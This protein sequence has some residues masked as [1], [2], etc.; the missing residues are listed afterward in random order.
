MI[1]NFDR[2]INGNLMAEGVTIDR[3]ASFADATLKAAKIASRGKNGEIPVLVAK[4]S[5]LEMPIEQM[6]KG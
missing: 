6:E 2:Y 5:E 3:A 1:Y 4:S